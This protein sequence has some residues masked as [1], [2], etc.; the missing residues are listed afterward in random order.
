MTLQFE[1]PTE[2]ISSRDA[3]DALLMLHS[4]FN[5]EDSTIDEWVEALEANWPDLAAQLFTAVRDV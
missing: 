4:R 3:A 2:T 1:R 5:R